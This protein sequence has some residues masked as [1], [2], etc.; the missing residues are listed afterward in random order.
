MA[1]LQMRCSAASLRS[2][3]ASSAGI[4]PHAAEAPATAATA[5]AAFSRDA[6]SAA[7]VAVAAFTAETASADAWKPP[8]GEPASREATSCEVGLSAAAVRA[9]RESSGPPAWPIAVPAE[10]AVSRCA[11][12][13]GSGAA[14]DDAPVAAAAAAVAGAAAGAITREQAEYPDS[15]ASMR[16]AS[17]SSVRSLSGRTMRVS[18][19]SNDRRGLVD[20]FN[21][22]DR[23]PKTPSKRAKRSGPNN[24]NSPVSS[25][26]SD[27]DTSSATSAPTSDI[28][29]RLRTRSAISPTNRA[30][31]APVSTYCAVQRK[32]AAASRV[33]TAFMISDI[34]LESSDPSIASA[35]ASVTLPSPNAII[36]SREVSALRRPPSARCAIKSSASP[37]NSTPSDTHTAPKRATMASADMR[38]KSNRWQREWM[39][40]GTFCGS[41]VARMNTT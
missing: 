11:R 40:S 37:S 14:L 25:R 10:L 41:V 5:E 2:V 21:S 1:E 16:S 27:S 36:C 30:R 34:S 32:H 35:P 15:S 23:S 6:T 12:A 33:P 29:Y 7:A 9:W 24:G 28:T 19:I 18:A 8:A 22:A 38:R 26:R 3:S 31:S 4:V 13:L 20:V 39:V 17:A